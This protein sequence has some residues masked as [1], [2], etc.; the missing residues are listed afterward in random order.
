MRY[1]NFKGKMVQVIDFDDVG[2]ERVL[3]FVDSSAELV[4]AV[5]AVHYVSDG[6]SSAQVSISPK[7]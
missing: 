3:E 2:G 1:E 5:L 7:G 4:G 6:W